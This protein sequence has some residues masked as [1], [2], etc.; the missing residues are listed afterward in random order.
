M[1]M[2]MMMGWGKRFIRVWWC[3]FGAGGGGEGTL[4]S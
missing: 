3:V 1:G 2:T 4:V